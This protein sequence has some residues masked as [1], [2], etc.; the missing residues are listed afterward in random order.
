MNNTDKLLKRL[1]S[2]DDQQAKLDRERGEISQELLLAYKDKLSV[3]VG[4]CF[5]MGDYDYAKI[6][7][8]PNYAWEGFH[9][10][11][12]PTELPAVWVCAGSEEMSVYI[13][14]VHSQA[15]YSDDPLMTIRSE[16]DEITLDEFNKNL[17]TVVGIFKSSGVSNG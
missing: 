9:R 15:C 14:T 16:H 17:D 6:I 10:I 8:T 11:Y 7:G 4:K 3:L 12:S 13:D 2:I 5:Y 1:K